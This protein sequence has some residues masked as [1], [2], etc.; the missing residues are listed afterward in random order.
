L[1]AA[2]DASRM[3]EYSLWPHSS[4]CTALLQQDAQ[5]LANWFMACSS[6]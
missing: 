4:A 2:A 6:C 1:T 5:R 3:L